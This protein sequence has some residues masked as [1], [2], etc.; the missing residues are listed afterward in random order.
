[1]PR[2]QL[3]PLAQQS[4][5]LTGA[6]SGIGLATA[7]LAARRG[8]KLMLV[9]RNEEALAS[10]R[11]EIRAA[12]GQAE[13]AVADVAERAQLEA[14]ATAAKATFGSIDSWVND[15][16][17]FAYGTLQELPLEDQRRVFDVIYWG[18]VHGTLVAA[19]ALATTGGAIVNLGS[20]LSE[21]AIPYQGP[22]C[23][24][25]FAVK[26]FT[27]AFRRESMARQAPLS[28]SLIK[29]A[30]IDT[31]FMEHARNHLGSRGTRNPPPAYHPNLV[32]RAILHACETPVRQLTVGGAGGLSLVIA[33]RAAPGLMDRAFALFGLPSQ[34]THD[35]GRA[36]RRDNLYAPREDGAERSS[37]GPF[38]RKTSL[39]LEAQLHPR[40][41]SAVIAATGA[42]LLAYTGLRARR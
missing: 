32:A 14:A 17:V 37:L 23:A 22:Y 1:M 25:K 27:E 34:T 26:G 15:A 29:P 18:T 10:V 41:T 16:G 9:A 13:Y 2:I 21:L 19:E 24:A 6:T 30:A 8:A 3:K 7:R 42:M 28:I 36:E 31:L 20:V 33:N 40:A 5:V 35:P 38:T 12:G 39:L 4:I 11:D